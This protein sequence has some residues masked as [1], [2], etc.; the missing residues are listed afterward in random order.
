MNL[1][2]KGTIYNNHATSVTKFKKAALLPPPPPPPSTQLPNEHDVIFAL[3]PIKLKSDVEKL[4]NPENKPITFQPVVTPIKVDREL[5]NSN[6]NMYKPYSRLTGIIG[7][8]NTSIGDKLKPLI[9][10]IYVVMP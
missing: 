6:N 1:G 3:S 8:T 4:N 2:A 10:E 7:E 9:N 5:V